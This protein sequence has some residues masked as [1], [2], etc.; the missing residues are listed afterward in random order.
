[1]AC[2][3]RYDGP[4]G[5]P[6]GGS[7]QRLPTTTCGGSVQEERGAGSKQEPQDAPMFTWLHSRRSPDSPNRQVH[8]TARTGSRDRAGTGSARWSPPSS[9][10]VGPRTCRPRP[11]SSTSRRS[12]PTG[13]S[14][15][16][17]RGRPTDAEQPFSSS[18]KTNGTSSGGLAN[19]P[20][21]AGVASLKGVWAELTPLKFDDKL[22]TSNS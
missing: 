3:A 16:P 2:Q 6:G 13:P 20:S 9:P 19:S 8:L 11:S 21:A 1:M 18:S 7:A 12:T 4:V 14:P 17:R 5:S 10:R 22:S 15:G